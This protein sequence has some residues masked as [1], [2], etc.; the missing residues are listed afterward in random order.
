ML[1]TNV[2]VKLN[3]GITSQKESIVLLKIKN[4]SYSLDSI[5]KIG[6]NFKYLIEV[7][8][9]SEIEGGDDK[10]TYEDHSDHSFEILKAEADALANIVELHIPSTVTSSFD[11][12]VMKFYL[13]AKM[14]MF[15]TFSVNNPELTIDNIEFFNP[16]N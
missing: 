9:P 12:E 14:K 1:R 15:N 3:D 6:V 4:F 11:Y 5:D 7:V 8:T 13:G 16:S 10:I 2:K